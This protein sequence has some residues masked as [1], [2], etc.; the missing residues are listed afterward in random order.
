MLKIWVKK[1]HYAELLINRKPRRALAL[2]GFF[3][4]LQKFIL[5]AIFPRVIQIQ[6]RWP[7]FWRT[8]AL[9]L[10]LDTLREIRDRSNRRLA[11]ASI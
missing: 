10:T 7:G 8:H 4:S 1:M 5:S 6:K 9:C 11:E 3:T 2:L